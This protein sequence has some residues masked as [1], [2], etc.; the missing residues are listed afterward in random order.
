MLRLNHIRVVPAANA[1]WKRLLQFTSDYRGVTGMIGAI[2]IPV[3]LFFG[4]LAVDLSHHQHLKQRLEASTDTAALHLAGQASAT[5]TLSASFL[6]VQGMQGEIQTAIEMGTG[7]LP[8]YNAANAIEASDVTIGE[9]DFSTGSFIETPPFRLVN[10]VRVEGELSP[11]RGN[12]APKFFSQLFGAETTIRS[13]SYAFVPPVPN[14]HTLNRSASRS[15]SITGQGDVDAFD[16][17]SDSSSAS[18]IYFKTRHFSGWGGAALF[19]PGDAVLAGSSTRIAQ[20][21]HNDMYALGDLLAGAE[22]PDFTNCTSVRASGEFTTCSTYINT[23]IDQNGPVTVEP[24]IY[25]GGLDL[26]G[27]GPVTFNPGVYVFEDGPFK[28]SG[29]VTA[30]GNGVLFYFT[31]QNA[32][33]Y[34]QQGRL[35]VKGRD[36]GKYQGFVVY[37]DRETTRG[38][39]HI[40]AASLQVVGT[41]YA[42]TGDLS[43]VNGNLNGSCHSL[44]MVA[45]NISL[46]DTHINLYPGQSVPA[47]GNVNAYP[48]PLALHPAL[49]P[50]L[51][52]ETPGA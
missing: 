4:A 14:I 21:V 43:F 39:T 40:I 12:E 37:S 27:A 34:L 44:C 47:F 20:A 42:P 3:L 6:T 1:S 36:T 11:A 24:G 31:G 30:T 46:H 25:R 50:S 22:D 38:L 18:A 41:I 48:A 15:L 32:R 23:V 16:G 17:W 10:A 19:T 52:I 13:K 29:N 35:R 45:D 2:T 8:A 5:R 51:V 9:W 28:M 33:L 26:A 49:Q 7:N